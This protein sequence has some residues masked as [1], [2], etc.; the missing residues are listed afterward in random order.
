MV[1]H[2]DHEHSD[3]YLEDY[4]EMAN[5]SNINQDNQVEDHVMFVDIVE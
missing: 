1:E 3:H 4:V 2:L 5:E